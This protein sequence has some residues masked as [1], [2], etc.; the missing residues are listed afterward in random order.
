[1][2]RQ[3]DKQQIAQLLSKFMAGET[4]LAEEQVLAQYFR[5]HDVGEEWAEYKEMFALFDSGEVDIEQGT[6]SSAPLVTDASGKARMLPKAVREKPKIV[7]LRWGVAAVAASAL[8]LLVLRLS[9]GAV[10]DKPAVTHTASVQ[11]PAQQPVTPPVV[12][13]KT[14]AVVAEVQPTPKPV[15]P[16]RRAIRKRSTQEKPLL[17]EAVPPPTLTEAVP[18]LTS[19]HLPPSTLH[20]TGQD[21]FLMA[22]AQAE[23]IRQRGERLH[24]EIAQLMTTP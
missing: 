19:L 9:Q 13:E 16:R 17:A 22:A 15:K 21:P 8:L 3:N 24:H 23:N 5:T 2:K 10:E 14:E 12:E 4:S 20:P 7:V 18:E 11:Q 1:M 6:E